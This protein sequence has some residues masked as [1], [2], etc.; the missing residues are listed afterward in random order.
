MS[1]DRVGQPPSSYIEST[2]CRLDCGPRHCPHPTLSRH[3]RGCVLAPKRYLFQDLKRG[4]MGVGEVSAL[5]AGGGE[6][7]GNLVVS[8]SNFFPERGKNP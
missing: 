3:N 7:E 4:R 1:G 6:E 2:H 8:F 5:V